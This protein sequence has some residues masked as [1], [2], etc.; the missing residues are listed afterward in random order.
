MYVAICLGCFNACFTATA[1]L[2]FHV[3]FIICFNLYWVP[4]ISFIVSWVRIVPCSWCCLFKKRI[5][6]GVLC[7]W[8]LLTRLVL[9]IWIRLLLWLLSRRLWLWLVWIL[10]LWS[11]WLNSY[12]YFSYVHWF[13]QFLNNLRDDGC[14]CE[15]YCRLIAKKFP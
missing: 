15:W 3:D 10:L 9:W 11:C 13:Q 14:C 8:L 2:F 4:F 1:A 5:W 6:N 12:A 7:V